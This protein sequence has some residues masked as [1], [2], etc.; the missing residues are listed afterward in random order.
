MMN[1]MDLTLKILKLFAI[2]CVVGMV[3]GSVAASTGQTNSDNEYPV[4]PVVQDTSENTTEV[5]ILIAPK[6]DFDRISSTD[7]IERGR[8]NGWITK[9][10]DIARGD[11]LILNITSRELSDVQNG[12]SKGEMFGNSSIYAVEVNPGPS[13]P[14]KKMWLNSSSS[15][16]IRNS[17]SNSIYVVYNTSN[18]K[19]SWLDEGKEYKGAK[20]TIGYKDIFIPRLVIDGEYKLNPDY[21]SSEP[22][23]ENL[24]GE[25][26]FWDRT[27]SIKIPDNLTSYPLRLNSNPRVN[28]TTSLAPGSS[29][30]VKIESTDPVYKNVSRYTTIHRASS[31]EPQLNNSKY[32]FTTVFDL[33]EVPNGANMTIW[34]FDD[35]RVLEKLTPIIK[36]TK[37]VNSSKSA[38]TQAPTQSTTTAHIRQTATSVDNSQNTESD[39]RTKNTSQP[40]DQSKTVGPNSTTG[41]GSGF[42]IL[43][44]VAAILTIILLIWVT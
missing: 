12:V 10:N 1:K 14:K 3:S 44:L 30:Q 2:V 29:I 4:E 41:T 23:S 42:G 17:T 8:E 34:V 19:L 36:S 24:T 13:L 35:R 33:S 31:I 38:T 22:N 20:P 39:R 28:G 5:S 43:P 21:S 25:F 11:V 16:I 9:S 32:I 37:G 7:S 40:R 6:E 15:K 18:P 26:T 27:A